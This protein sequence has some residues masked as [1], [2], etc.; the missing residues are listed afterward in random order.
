MV[1]SRVG[2]MGG[3][4]D[5]IHNGHLIIAEAVRDAYALEK[6][7]FIPSAEP[8][9]KPTMTEAVHRLRMTELAVVSNPHF[10]VLDMELKREGPSYSFDTLKALTAIYGDRYGFHFIIG[11]DELNILPTWHRI[12]ELI[13]LCHFI[14]A[15]RQGVA[16]DMHCV[17]RTLGASAEARF[18]FCDTP[19]L[20]IS[21]TDIRERIRERRSV[22]YLLPEAVTAYIEKEGLYV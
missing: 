1:I 11:T 7:F 17:Q 22:R 18:H 13:S 20:E 9:H 6:V 3:T 5:P 8:P 12:G 19:E 10:E 4:F 16:A 15:K 14:V 2:I 21:S